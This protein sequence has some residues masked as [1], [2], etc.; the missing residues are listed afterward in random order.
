MS[1]TRR[2]RQH[3]SRQDSWSTR[4]IGDAFDLNAY[5]ARYYLNAL[6][7]KGVLCRSTIQR[8]APALW[9]L[10]AAHCVSPMWNCIQGTHYGFLLLSDKILDGSRLEP[11]STAFAQNEYNV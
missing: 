3:R 2:N 7:R 8:G 9:S 4:E 5:M 10:P 11:L 6:C 1:H